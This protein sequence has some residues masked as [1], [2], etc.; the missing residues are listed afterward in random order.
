VS[1]GKRE[2]RVAAAAVVDDIEKYSEGEMELLVQREIE[3]YVEPLLFLP[4]MIWLNKELSTLR[5][6]GQEVG[7]DWA[8]MNTIFREQVDMIPAARSQAASSKHREIRSVESS[9]AMRGGNRDPD[10]AAR[11]TEI[12]NMMRTN[13]RV[14][15]QEICKRL[16]YRGIAVPDSWTTE[17]KVTWQETLKKYANRVH[18]IISVDR[19]IILNI[20]KV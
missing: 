14:S 15:T 9:G 5:K 20:K 17:G 18:K 7:L 12:E 1:N 2:F 3:E 16:D 19:G 6:I 11:R 13:P 4:D 10:V 8:P